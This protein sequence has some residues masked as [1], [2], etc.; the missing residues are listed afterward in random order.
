MVGGGGAVDESAG[1]IFDFNIVPLTSRN[2]MKG[3]QIVGQV[4]NEGAAI[5][6]ILT[7]VLSCFETTN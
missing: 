7:C 6:A 4:V 2:C 1:N 5:Q 3:A